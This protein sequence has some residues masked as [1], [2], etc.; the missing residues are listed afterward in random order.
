MI[1]EAPQ[2]D[3]QVAVSYRRRLEETLQYGTPPQQKRVIEPWVDQIQ[4]TPETLEVEINYRVP[5]FVVNRVGAG[6]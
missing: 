4:L 1:G 2:M 5:E 3:I 6:V